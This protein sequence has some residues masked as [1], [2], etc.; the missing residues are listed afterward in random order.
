MSFKRIGILGGGQLGRMLQE[1]AQRWNMPVYCMDDSEKA[2]AALYKDY[3]TVGNIRDYD[4][5]LAFG[6][7]KDVITIEIEHVNLD[8]LITLEKQGKEIHPNPEALKIIKNKNRQ[9]NYYK[10]RNIPIPRFMDFYDRQEALEE[11]PNWPYDIP[12]IYKA[13]EMG[14]DGRGVRTIYHLDNVHDI[15][16]L[17]GAFEEKIDI[18]IE[19]AVMLAANPDG[20]MVVY[21]PVAMYFNE[22]DHILAEVHY[23]CEIDKGSADQMNEIAITI[24]KDLRICGLCAF[25]FFITADDKVLL[26]EIAP[27]PHNSMHLSMDNAITSQFEQHLRGISNLPMGSTVMEKA[28]I[29]YNV[30]GDTTDKRKANW[31]GWE[32]IL[33]LSDTKVH[34]YGKSEIKP[35]RKMGHINIIGDNLNELKAKLQA[36]KAHFKNAING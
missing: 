24:M 11:F 22:E 12:C 28:A 17:P 32:T 33:S 31:Q 4:D 25:E 27:R 16:N 9:K 23:P 19:V 7:D 20:E 18:K 30:L 13:A 1:V 2:P 36:I 8:A 15:E 3:F 14:Y 29:M 21:P 10:E 26:N 6:Q 34:L 35:A 5:V